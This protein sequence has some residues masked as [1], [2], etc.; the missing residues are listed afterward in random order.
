MYDALIF[1]MDG[2]LVNRIKAIKE[3]W[4]NSCKNHGWNKVFT[5]ED[6]K[7][8]MGLRPRQ[9][10][11]MMFPNLDPD[12]AQMQ[13]EIC[14]HEEIAYLLEHEGTSYI[15]REL[16]KTL[17]SKYKIFIVSNCLEGYIETYLDNFNFNEFVIDS[18]NA[19]NGKTK[20]ENI[21][22]VVKSYNLKNPLYVGDTILDYKSSCE[23]GIGF[24]FASYGFGNVENTLKIKELKELLS[25]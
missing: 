2:T 22:D 13:I 4:T 1:D 18:R 17:A 24:C 10:G 7:S 19:G 6:I 5:D 14:T 8:I 23:A 3:A 25:L 20:A 9:M 16:F 21:K 12:I 11:M 15:D